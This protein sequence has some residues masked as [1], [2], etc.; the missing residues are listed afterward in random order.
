MASAASLDRSFVVL[1]ADNPETIDEV[2]GYLRCAGLQAHASRGGSP[3]DDVPARAT[4]VVW[5]ADDFADAAVVKAVSALRRRRPG[6]R[7]LLITNL[8][9]RFAQLL[10]RQMGSLVPLVLSKS[11]LGS[12]IL[13]A[14]RSPNSIG[15]QSC[16]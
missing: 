6:L 15:P 16:A 8:P 13:A 14:L 11:A 5:F 2:Q 10:D 12:E 4:A 1:V 7:I 3:S 9:G